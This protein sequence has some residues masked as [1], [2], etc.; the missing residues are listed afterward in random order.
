MGSFMIHTNRV[1]LAMVLVCAMVGCFSNVPPP[2][3][4]ASQQ[5][6]ILDGWGTVTD[7]ASD[8]ILKAEN[9]KLTITI[10][11]GTHDLSPTSGGMSALRVLRKIEGDF[12]AQV[13]VTGEFKPGDKAHNPKT[14]PYNA[15]GLLIWQDNKN[16]VRFERRD[17][18][19]ANQN[20]YAS[21]PAL[22]EYFKNGTSQQWQS[23]HKLELFTG[24]STWLELERR[25]DK[26]IA[27]VSHDGKNWIGTSEIAVSL[28]K[29]VWVGVLAINTSVEPFVAEF[30]ELKIG[31]PLSAVRKAEELKAVAPKSRARKAEAAPRTSM[32]RDSLPAWSRCTRF[33]C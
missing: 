18:W 6:N 10:P 27:A 14:V 23:L 4:Q 29:T 30:A 7:P 1:R 32:R 21:P 20:K 17:W 8:C 22:P 3:L 15:A 33:R 11:G 19:L 31:A 28:P 24:K 2:R 9:G 26:L 13:K 5:A 12:R 16:Y 25:G